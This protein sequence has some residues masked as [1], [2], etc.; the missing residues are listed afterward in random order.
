MLKFSVNI[1]TLER[2][3]AV[4]TVKKMDIPNITV[5]SGLKQSSDVCCAQSNHVS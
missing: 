3:A 4:I 1:L 2:C 5:K